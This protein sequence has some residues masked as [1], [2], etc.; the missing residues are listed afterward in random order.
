MERIPLLNKQKKEV[1]QLWCDIHQEDLFHRKRLLKE[2]CHTND[3]DIVLAIDYIISQIK[4]KVFLFYN[5]KAS[6]VS[7]KDNGE[8]CTTDLENLLYSDFF[9]EGIVNYYEEYTKQN[10]HY[11]LNSKF[12]NVQL[13][14][15][16]I[17]KEDIELLNDWKKEFEK[18]DINPTSTTQNTNLT[19]GNYDQERTKKLYEECNNVVFKYC[20]LNDFVNSLNNPDVCKIEVK[21]KNLLYVL[22]TYFF[23]FFGDE[24]EIKIDLLN[25]RFD[26]SK[27]NYA[28]KKYSYE[29]YT[30]SQ[31][32]FD[33]ILAKI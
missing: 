31:K 4:D 3:C 14:S 23:N 24:N 22:Y 19:I 2:Y 18:I 28:K 17:V 9:R 8:T 21:N 13:I 6:Y 12:S 10:N 7:D 27:K 16:K 20:K 25:D 5:S 30:P 26:I 29:H 1:Y 32:E 11:T 33:K 15:E